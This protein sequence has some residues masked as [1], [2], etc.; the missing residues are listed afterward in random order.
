MIRAQDAE[1]KHKAVAADLAE[2]LDLTEK[3]KRHLENYVGYVKDSVGSL[4]DQ[5]RAST[6]GRDRA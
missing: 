5:S 3:S 4:V 6:A 1:R 2:R